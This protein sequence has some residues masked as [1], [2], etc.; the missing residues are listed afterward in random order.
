MTV[1]AAR[2]NTYT[3]G[4]E[5][6]GMAASID[7]TTSEFNVPVPHHSERIPIT[8][9]KTFSCPANPAILV[10]FHGGGYIMGCREMVASTC[11]IKMC[12]IRSTLCLMN[13]FQLSL[14]SM[15][16]V[17]AFTRGLLSSSNRKKRR[18]SKHA[19]ILLI[20]KTIPSNNIN[21]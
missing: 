2:N 21:S 16:R 8:V 10:Y 19:V 12:Y 7:G 11:T 18:P 1:E 14:Y 4:A 15:R 13:L 5:L 17:R 6:D 9:Y 20:L 3:L